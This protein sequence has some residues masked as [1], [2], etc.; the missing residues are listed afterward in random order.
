VS[1]FGPVNSTG[2]P[3]CCE[4]GCWST[5]SPTPAFDAE[6]RQI[7]VR[8]QGRF[9]LVLEGA[10]G[11]SHK[12]PGTKLFPSDPT[13][14]PDPQILSANSLGNGSTTVCDTGPP[15]EGGGVPAVNPPDFRDGQDVTDALRDLMCRFSVQSTSETACTFD[16]YGLFSFISAGTTRQFCFQVPQT[17]VFPDGDTILAAQMRDTSGSLG[18]RKEIVIRVGA[19]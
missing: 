7:F 13:A 1:F 12:D 10:R 2:C 9:L 19:P 16:D 18:P 3:F 14:R 8:G 17:V 6:G 4:P 15:P 5:P 11:T